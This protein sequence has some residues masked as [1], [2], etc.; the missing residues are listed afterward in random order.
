[1]ENSETRNTFSEKEGS[2]VVAAYFQKQ[3]GPGLSL[4]I[5]RGV[6]SAEGS[7]VMR[8]VCPMW[9]KR[10]VTGVEGS[11]VTGAE[12]PGDP[13][14]GL[15]VHVCRR[16]CCSG[17]RGY[18]SDVARCCRGGTLRRWRG[19]G[20]RAERGSRG[21]R[22]CPCRC[23]ATEGSEVVHAVIYVGREVTNAEGSRVMRAVLPSVVEAVD[24]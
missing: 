10:R 20:L 3:R 13:G 16:F 2:G 9:S 6:T 11:R 1:M 12:C 4:Q 17:I 14:P 18:A 21:V 8:A 23:S 22:G 5:C 15:S 7:R 19:P 24:S